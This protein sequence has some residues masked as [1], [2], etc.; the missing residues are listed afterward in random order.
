MGGPLGEHLGPKS[1]A[2][3]K[4]ESLCVQVHYI[5]KRIHGLLESLQ[6]LGT[7]TSVID[8]EQKKSV[9]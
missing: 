6:F 5:I 3:L 7:K 8:H 2:S 4:M 9:Q 1:F